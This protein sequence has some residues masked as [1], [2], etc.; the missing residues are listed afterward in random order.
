MTS[1]PLRCTEYTRIAGWMSALVTTATFSFL[2]DA[3]D[4]LPLLVPIEFDAGNPSQFAFKSI[5]LIY[6]P[7]G[8]Q[9][10]L[11]L[12][13]LAIVALLV[14][15]TAE[16]KD[17]GL[18]AAPTQHA[19]EAIALMAMIWI[20]FQAVNAW[21]L[22]TL[23]RRTFDAHQEIYVVALITAITATVFIVTRAVLKVQAAEGH[24]AFGSQLRAPVLDHRSRPFAVA[25]LAIALG[26]G[27][28]AP[29]YILA[30]VWGGLRPI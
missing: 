23:Y 25:A 30:F 13:F 14:R 1:L 16:S 10:A 11:S 19:A 8:L 20:A 3:Y 29:L 28:G 9:V 4:R 24:A 15:R 17:R 21:R 27:L 22:A 12:V 26:I 6:L 2:H 7:F 18:A 5:G